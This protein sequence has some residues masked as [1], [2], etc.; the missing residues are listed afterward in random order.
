MA[1]L[2]CLN[3]I[4]LKPMYSK[5]ADQIADLHKQTRQWRQDRNVLTAENKAQKK[6]IDKIRAIYDQLKLTGKETQRQVSDAQIKKTTRHCKSF[7]DHTLKHYQ[8]KKD[9]PCLSSSDIPQTFNLSELF[10]SWSKDPQDRSCLFLDMDDDKTREKACCSILNPAEWNFESAMEGSEK[11]VDRGGLTRAF[12]NGVWEQ[13]GTLAV[14][15]NGTLVNL[16]ADDEACGVSPKF[17]EHLRSEI[18]RSFNV[19]VEKLPGTDGACEVILKVQKFYRAFGRL[20]I[21]SLATDH[22]LPWNLIPGVY[23]ACK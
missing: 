8:N 20:M 9:T 17:D 10:D 13:A 21:H 23:R 4:Q 3:R 11:G 19:S 18:A 15:S 7:L 22:H 6:E 16:F 12:L 14:N 2:F 1:I 5:I